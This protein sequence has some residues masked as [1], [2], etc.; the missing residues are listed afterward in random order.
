MLNYHDLLQESKQKNLTEW[1]KWEIIVT[2]CKKVNK[3][4]WPEMKEED[5]TNILN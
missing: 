3:R 5:E 2:F 1:E 4:I